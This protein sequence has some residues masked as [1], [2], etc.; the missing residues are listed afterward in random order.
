MTMVLHDQAWQKMTIDEWNGATPPKVRGTWNLHNETES[1]NLDFFIL[2]SSLS[3]IVGRPGQANY[4]RANTFLDAFV[5][6]R[7]GKRLPCQG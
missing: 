2:F 6:F 1:L 4:A 3:G 7:T 5:K